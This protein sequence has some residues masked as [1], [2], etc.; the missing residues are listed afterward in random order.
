MSHEGHE[1]HLTFDYHPGLP[2]STGKTFMWLFLSTEIMF[3]SALIGTYVVLR[4]GAAAWPSPHEVHLV[5][6]IGALNT[7][8]LLFSSL[9]IV[10]A[11][12]SAK[13][14]QPSAAKGWLLLTLTLGAIFLGIKGFEYNAKF[15]HG[16]YPQRPR[17]QIWEKPDLYYVSAVRTRLMDLRA[18]LA[19]DGAEQ[20]LLAQEKTSLPNEKQGVTERIAELEAMKD[21]SEDD[22]AALKAARKRLSEIE[23]RIPEVEERLAALTA[24]AKERADRDKVCLT[25][26]EG[27]V[28][29]AEASVRKTTN[30]AVVDAAFEQLADEIVPPH[31]TGYEDTTPLI[32]DDA[33]DTLHAVGL[34][35]KHPWL[36]LPICIP[37]GNMWA[38]TYFLL[39]GFHALHVLVGLI[40]FVI[41]LLFLRLDAAKAG[42]LE[43]I[44]LYWHFVDLVWIF[45]FPLL[46]LF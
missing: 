25:L 18:E 10:L 26:L 44:G 7:A 12:E 31:V 11:F 8:V 40:V 21:H 45:L 43:N 20:D 16:I 9:T 27:P 23:S 17:S 36:E 32:G 28:K 41:V 29:E 3:F 13:R 42:V 1:H 37:G 14:N 34:N 5:E 19:A 24:G 6:E 15:S 35:E 46:Y 30:L 38:S 2:I 33:Q 4:F 39:T 22:E